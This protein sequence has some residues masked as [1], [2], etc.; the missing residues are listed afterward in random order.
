MN[1]LQIKNNQSVAISAI[2][3]FD[4]EAFYAIA[5]NLCADASN[6]V[7]NYYAYP[8]SNSLKFICCI[9][10]DKDASIHVF[11]HEISNYESTKAIDAISKE[12][13][14]FQMFEREI[15]EN[16]G[17]DF[18]DHPWN[19]PV[20]LAADRTDKTQTLQNYPFYSLDS[21]ETHEV[22]V[23]PIHAGVI[24]PGHFRFICNGENVLHLEI[25]LGYQHRGIEKLFLSKTHLI[26]RTVLAESIAGDSS[27][28]HTLAFVGN[29]ESLLGFEP[30][31]RLN[32][33]RALALELERMAIHVGDLS[34]FC[35]DVAYQLGSSVFGALRTPLIN[36]FQ[37][38][39]GNRF[40]KGLIRTG[41]NPYA[42]TPALKERLI[43]M[44]EEFEAKYMEMAR[45]TFELPSV[46]NRF[47]KTGVL[48]KT[49]AELIGA[50]GMTARMAGLNRDIRKSHP[51]GYFAEQK[52]K[53][54]V[55]ESGDVFAR[56]MLRNLEVQHS[57]EY[58]RIMLGQLSR[59]EEEPTTTRSD[60]YSQK[61]KPNQFSISFTEGWRGEICHCAITNEKGELA[62]YKVKDPS[63]H[64][65]LALGLVLRQNEISDF[66]INNKSFNFS[67]CGFDL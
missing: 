7:V 17:I 39:C 44:L 3:V 51:F 54:E 57:L 49:Q 46:L 38:W 8:M 64:N 61:L 9:A 65:W 13:F 18:L 47:E 10:E 26:Q 21:D 63:F 41:Y 16:F 2:P 43:K 27:V 62:H 45:K 59:T 34:G 33:L 25:Q 56:G 23:G 14:A 6:H 11:S 4:Y 58:I 32:M 48:T 5:V 60:F 50:V 36:Y 35:T 42:F 67:Y 24:E 22:G 30:S 15:K 53:T 29:M 40:A 37:W 1:T 31:Q 20:R 52:Y 28:G 55:I 12:I 19:K 66:P